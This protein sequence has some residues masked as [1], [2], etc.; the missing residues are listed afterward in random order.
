MM[1]NEVSATWGHSTVVESDPAD[2]VVRDAIYVPFRPDVFFDH[3]PK[4]G[5]YGKDGRLISAGAYF[6][7]PTHHLV[8]QSVSTEIS[9]AG[10]DVV[11]EELV[12]GGPVVTFYGH[13]ITA[14]LARLWWLSRS[15]TKRLRILWHSHAD[16]DALFAHGYIRTMLEALGLERSDFVRF[17]RPTIIRRLWVPGPA[18]EEQSF[19]HRTFSDLGNRV[20]KAC[21]AEDE[22]RGDATVYLSKT[23]LASGITRLRG[24][25]IIEARMAQA[26]AEIV[27]PQDL[28]LKDQIRLFARARTVVGT[29]GS[30]FHTI[31]FVRTP[32]RVIGL[33]GTNLVNAN[34]SLIDNVKATKPLYVYPEISATAIRDEGGFASTWIIEDMETVAQQLTSYI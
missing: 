4:W 32:P 7:G 1:L 17:E 34:Y 29:V 31:L 10:L 12:Y 24:E 28:S 19:I 6:R 13:F 5:L 3:D 16:P 30:A 25:E 8:G 22:T 9:A 18:M 27:H 14:T 11:D 2:E 15:S 33:T 20:G 23:K 21:G 26:G